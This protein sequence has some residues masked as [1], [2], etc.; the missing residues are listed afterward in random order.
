MPGEIFKD[1]PGFSGKYKVSN[2]G[3]I[4]AKNYK[5]SK[6]E[7]IISQSKP[8]QVILGQ[9]MPKSPRFFGTY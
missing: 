3:R 7:K 6:Y 1:I 9:I 4:L 5:G 8:G 2:K